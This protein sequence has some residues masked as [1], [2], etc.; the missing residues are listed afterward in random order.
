MTEN[1]PR[2]GPLAVISVMTDDAL[3]VE[4]DPPNR[5]TAIIVFENLFISFSLVD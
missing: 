4:T 5:R 3:A 1:V 2:P